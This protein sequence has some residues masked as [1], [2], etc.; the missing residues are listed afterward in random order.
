MVLVF[1]S[2]ELI[3]ITNEHPSSLLGL[4]GYINQQGGCCDF[5]VCKVCEPIKVI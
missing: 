3:N 5:E 1:T 2:Q 4:K